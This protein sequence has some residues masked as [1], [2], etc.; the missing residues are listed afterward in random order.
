MARTLTFFGV[1]SLEHERENLCFRQQIYRP[2]D[3]LQ[4]C[5]R[6]HVRIIHLY[7]RDYLKI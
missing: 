6:I 7:I 3:V 1:E 4:N 2:R 5:S